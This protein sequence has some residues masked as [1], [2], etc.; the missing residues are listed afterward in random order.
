[1]WN[2]HLTRSLYFHRRQDT[3]P[4]DIH[5]APQQCREDGEC[6]Y[7]ELNGFDIKPGTEKIIICRRE[8]EQIV[9]HN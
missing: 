7:T 3:H 4:T 6:F 2:G 8:F 5:P 9:L 1:M